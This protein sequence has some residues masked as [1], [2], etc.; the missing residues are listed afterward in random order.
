MV[1]AFDERRAYVAQR[2]NAVQGMRCAVPKGAF[3]A[4]PNVT[5]TGWDERA[6]AKA[7]LE[8]AGVATIAGTDFGAEGAGFIRLS[9]ANSLEN[10]GRAIDRMEGFLADARAPAVAQGVHQPA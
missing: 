6:L 5:G 1:S 7:L 10:I 2:L 4:F 8:E 9:C 3:Y